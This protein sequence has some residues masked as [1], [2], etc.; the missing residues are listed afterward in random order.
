MIC[1]NAVYK[2]RLNEDINLDKV[3]N[4]F[5]N[6]QSKLYVGRPTQLKIKCSNNIVCLLFSKGAIRIMG[7]GINLCDAT[8]ILFTEILPLFT[9]A[10]P[11]LEVQTMTF[12]GYTGFEVNLKKFANDFDNELQTFYN[13]EIFSALR[14]NKFKPISVN[15]FSSGKIVLCGG[16][17]EYQAQRIISLIIYYCCCV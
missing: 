2:T 16:K 10:R 1:V 11:M 8:S 13:F 12:V 17:C 7:K 3:A 14:I 4:L 6:L 15:L 5:S 9:N